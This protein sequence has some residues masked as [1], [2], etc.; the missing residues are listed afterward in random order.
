MDNKEDIT[1][2]SDCLRILEKAVS[3]SEVI[4]NNRHKEARLRLLKESATILVMAITII[5]LNRI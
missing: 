2:M 5:V 1:L 3:N 4:E